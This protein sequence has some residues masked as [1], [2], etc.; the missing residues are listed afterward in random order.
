MKES[1]GRLDVSAAV[2]CFPSGVGARWFSVEEKDQRRL[3]GSHLAIRKVG[4][5]V[6]N[7][8]RNLTQ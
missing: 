6:T 2:V 1:G 5:P 3:P 7:V 4:P 8:Y